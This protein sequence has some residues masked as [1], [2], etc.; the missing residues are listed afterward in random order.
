MEV[1]VLIVL[2]GE[3]SN[4]GA[5]EGGELQIATKADLAVIVYMLS[6]CPVLRIAL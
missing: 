6:L 3:N 1:E 2:K 5:S 4:G